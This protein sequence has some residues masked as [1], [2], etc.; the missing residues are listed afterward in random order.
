MTRLT[1]RIGGTGGPSEWGEQDT[2][3]SL[4]DE[5]DVEMWGHFSSSKTWLIHDLT[6]HFGRNHELAE[7]YP[8]GWECYL[9]GERVASW[10]PDRVSVIAEGPQPE[11]TR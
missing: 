4:F 7:K 6:S 10:E 8:D 2:W 1:I 3:G 11:A 9:D 5:A